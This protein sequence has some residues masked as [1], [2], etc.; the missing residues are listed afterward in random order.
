METRRDRK[1]AGETARQAPAECGA[2]AQAGMAPRA[3][4]PEEA[5]LLG[6]LEAESAGY[7]PACVLGA[8]AELDL[9]TA[10]LAGGGSMSAGQAAELL[11]CDRRGMET[12]LDALAALGYF[13]KE[14]AGEAARYGVAPGFERLLDSRDPSSYIPMLR[15]RASIQRSWSRLSWAVRDGLPQK[16]LESFLGPAQDSAS[17]IMAMNAVAVRLAGET[18]EALDQAGVFSRL[19]PDLKLIDIG[20][21]SGTYTEAFLRRLPQARAA[22]F[23]LPAGIEAARRR[24]EGSDME[25]RVELIEGDFTRRGF[26]A[27]FQ[28]AWISAIIHQMSREES[29]DLYAKAYAALEPGGI[30]A[31]RDFV[32]DASRTSPAAGALFGVNML[33]QTGGGRVF[34]FGEMREDL[35][36]SGFRD[37]RLAVD[38]PSM[39]AVVTAAKPA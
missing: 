18:V 14:G 33:V 32:M 9:A 31:V 3:E 6:K 21:A 39:A 25:S 15:H 16:G 5:S 23:D 34:T 12:L 10:V 22:L 20:G 26:P 24:F 2:S 7:Q 36:A 19:K 11:G 27:G 29:R 13:A 28:L 17:F 37:V 1:K 4:L 30:A 38:R 35:E 8:M